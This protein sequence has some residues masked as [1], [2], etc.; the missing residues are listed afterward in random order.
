MSVLS[1]ISCALVAE[2][3]AV[4]AAELQ[5][6]LLDHGCAEA[7]IAYG[8]DSAIQA[9]KDGMQFAILDVELAGEPCTELANLLVASG[10]PFIYYSGYRPDDFPELPRAPWVNKPASTGELAAA[11]AAAVAQHVPGSFAPSSF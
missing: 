2:D 11:I 8:V 10:V 3:N 9:L 6:E 4:L 7:V 1:H 5:N